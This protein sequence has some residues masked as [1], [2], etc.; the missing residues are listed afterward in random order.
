MPNELKL[1]SR[2]VKQPE[3][4]PVAANPEVEKLQ[5]ELEAAMQKIAELT[6]ERDQARSDLATARDALTRQDGLLTGERTARESADAARASAEARAVA[7]E[8]RPMPTFDDSG[9]RAALA[10]SEEKCAMAMAA[11]EKAERAT[12]DALR[13]LRAIVEQPIEVVCDVEYGHD[14]RPRRVI[15]REK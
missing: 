12:E 3:P 8:S 11:Q 10:A 7:A 5:R 2:F 6:Q 1:A 13:R 15:V 9:L 14:D 4:Q